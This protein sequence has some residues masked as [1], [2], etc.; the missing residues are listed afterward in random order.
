[1]HDKLDEH[2][3]V[4]TQELQFSSN[5][6]GLFQWVA[7]FYYFHEDATQ[8]L[9]IFVNV[10]AIP[11]TPDGIINYDGGIK[12]NAYAVYGQGS[13]RLGAFR[14]T[15]GLRYGRDEKNST[16]DETITDPFHIIS[17]YGSMSI[18]NPQSKSWDS[19][20]PKVGVDYFVNDNVMLYAS[21]SRGFKSGGMNLQGAGEVFN[22]E[23]LWDYEGGIKATWFDGRLRTNLDGFH[24]DDQGMQVNIFNGATTLVT[25]LP[26]A[27]INGFEANIT[28]LLTPDLKVDLGLSML[29][30]E[31][32]NYN[33][34]N[35]VTNLPVNLSG[36]I[37]P[38]AP[39]TSL[40]ASA[41]YTL[42]FTE[43]G[44]FTLR[45]E[46]KYQSRMFF[47]YY[48]DPQASQGG[49]TIVN[50]RLSY[51]SPD[52]RWYAA[53]FANNLADQ[54]YRQSV[55]QSPTLLGTLLFWGPPR[56]FGVELGVHY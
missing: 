15:A 19:L 38:R 49:Y 52:G 16:F 24:Y 21:A 17:P 3:R 51:D 22:P 54:L 5:D 34:I 20:S 42:P 11:G 14:F 46:M 53:A 39:K 33:T 28:A 6:E 26:R 13:Y 43:Y 56:T 27:A 1:V 10:P 8:L 2:S 25:N 40:T 23:R 45:G 18:L 55:I 9:P 32:G 44:R 48:D 7:G 36:N 4:V 35:P 37:L 12:T 29:D 50:A 31:V 41:D 47:T 30:A